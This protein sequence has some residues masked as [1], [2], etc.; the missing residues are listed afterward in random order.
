MF[1]WRLATRLSPTLSWT[2]RWA[3]ECRRCTRLHKPRLGLFYLALQGT[4][5]AGAGASHASSTVLTVLPMTRTTARVLRLLIRVSP[6]VLM[7][8][9]A[10][11]VSP[12]VGPNVAW[13]I[14]TVAGLA[15]M[16]A[17]IASSSERLPG[18]S[19]LKGLKAIAARGDELRQFQKD[20]IAKARTSVKILD[21]YWGDVDQFRSV[22]KTALMNSSTCE[23]KVLLAKEGGRFSSIRAGALPP[24]VLD[25]DSHL[26]DTL[27]SLE[28][29]KT[30]LGTQGK[31][32]A[33]RLNL[34][35]FD[36]IVPGPMIIVDDS[37]VFAGTFMQNAAGSP[38]SPVIWLLRSR[39]SKGAPLG[40]YI[41]TFDN[42]WSAA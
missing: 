16:Y 41:E 2:G 28:E 15:A 29:L 39:F 40:A 27:H 24:G 34:K 12:H 3:L 5:S 4:L 18:E 22:I 35:H 31:G 33:E 6:V 26:P 23:V 17:A 8:L 25:V 30:Y 10:P 9:S 7:I 13:P 36:A 20:R 19:W 14:V 11:I 37:D 21:S 32:L 1:G 38:G 42:L